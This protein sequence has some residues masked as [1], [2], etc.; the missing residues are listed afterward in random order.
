M[1]FAILLTS[2][3]LSFA[4]Y[5]SFSSPSH[6]YVPFISLSFRNSNRPLNVPINT[7][8]SLTRFT[9]PTLDTFKDNCVS[10][11]DYAY[12]CKGDIELNGKILLSNF[13]FSI[14][15]KQMLSIDMIRYRSGI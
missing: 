14:P 2:L 6:D 3:T 5:I 4:Q 7:Q 11:H 8:I 12:D 1:L 10:Q 9:S 15:T 13:N